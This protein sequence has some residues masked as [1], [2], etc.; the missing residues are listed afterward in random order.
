MENYRTAY[1]LKRTDYISSIFSDN[2]LIIIGHMVEKAP[3]DLKPVTLK[4]NVEYDYLTKADYLKRLESTFAK[5]NYINIHFEETDV[6]QGKLEHVYGIQLEQ[7]Y[8]S[9]NYADKGY[10]FLLI[11]LREPEKPLIHVR[12]WQPEKN[13]DGS[14]FGVEDFYFD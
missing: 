12:T 13:A 4:D 6:K 7:D 5:N 1:T 9:T 8:T 2:A 3:N 10:L 11:D 14:I